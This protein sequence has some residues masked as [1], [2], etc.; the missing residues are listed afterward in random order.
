MA[1]CIL[2]PQ[3]KAKNAWQAITNLVENGLLYNGEPEEI[4]EFLNIVRFKNNKSRYLVE[5]RELMTRDVSISL[6]PFLI[7]RKFY[8]KLMIL[9]KKEN[10]F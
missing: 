5:F 10:G 9:L 4:V 3:S 7:L 2:T 8:Q 1:F 6:M